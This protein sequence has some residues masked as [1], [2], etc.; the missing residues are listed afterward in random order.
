MV[1]TNSSYDVVSES[2]PSFSTYFNAG[3]YLFK[4]VF[5]L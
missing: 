3:E 5:L 1:K 2:A 4:A